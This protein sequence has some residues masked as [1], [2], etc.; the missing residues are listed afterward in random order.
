M[1]IYVDLE[2]CGSKCCKTLKNVLVDTGLTFTTITQA[3]A[4]EIGLPMTVPKRFL[5]GK[6]IST[7]PVGAAVVKIEGREMLNLIT[8]SKEGIRTIG[9]LSLES[10]RFKVDPIKGKLEYLGPPLA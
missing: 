2:I 10:F 8:I 5:R 6:D 9:T 3:D 4:D 1:H 7:Y